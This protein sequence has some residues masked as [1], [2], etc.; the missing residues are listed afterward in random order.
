MPASSQT[1]SHYVFEKASFLGWCQASE[2]QANAH[3]INERL[4]GAGEPLLVFTQTPLPAHPGKGALDHPPSGDHPEA[5]LSAQFCQELRRIALQLAKLGV[6]HVHPPAI[7]LGSPAHQGS[8]V[9]LIRPDL[10]QAGI[11]VTGS[12]GLQRPPAPVG[13]L[14]G[15]EGWPRGPPR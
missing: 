12:S 13:R 15:R 11:G 3:E 8:G 2:E 7:F 10:L 6:D 1:R 4:L 9:A 14:C 5:R